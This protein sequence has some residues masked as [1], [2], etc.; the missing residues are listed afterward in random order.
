MVRI[1]SIHDS[2]S[3]PRSLGISKE[4]YQEVEFMVTRAC[5]KYRQRNGEVLLTQLIEELAREIQNENEFTYAVFRLGASLT[6]QHVA[7]TLSTDS[8]ARNI[9]LSTGRIRPNFFGYDM[10][11]PD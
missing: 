5:D 6:L 8:R 11:S 1:Q 3:L 10:E 4:R 2:L 9:F 7:E